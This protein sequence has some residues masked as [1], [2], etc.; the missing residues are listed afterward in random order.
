MWVNAEQVNESEWWLVGGVWGGVGGEG[1][2][3]FQLFRIFCCLDSGVDVD[4]F[5]VNGD[6]GDAECGGDFWV[7]VVTAVVC[8]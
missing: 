6:V 8:A 7:G 1:A 5:V 4:F 3:V 2:A